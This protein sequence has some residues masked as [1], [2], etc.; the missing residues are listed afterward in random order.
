MEKCKKVCKHHG[1]TQYHK[2]KSGYLHCTKC[3]SEKVAQCRRKCK[4]TLVQEF[5]GRCEI[6]LYNKCKSALDFHHI[7]PETKSFGISG[8]GSTISIAKKR[9]EALKCVLL[10]ANC[11][12]EVEEGITEVPLELMERVRQY[13]EAL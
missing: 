6:C 5:G 13:L 3:R 10:C 8:N 1:L 11:H 9:A 7:F 4:T 12:R 2:E